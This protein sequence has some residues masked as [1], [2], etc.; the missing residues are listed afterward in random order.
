MKRLSFEGK[1]DDICGTYK[2]VGSAGRPGA[3]SYGMKKGVFGLIC[4]L[5]GLLIVPLCGFLYLRFGIPPVAV[6][7]PAF[8]FEKQIV[9]VPLDAR[10]KREMPGASPLQPTAENVAAGAAIY[11]QNCAFCHGLPGHDSVYADHM[12]PPTPQLWKAHGHGV[13]G[14][15]DDPVGETFWKVKNGIRLTGMP[16]YADLLSQDQM[17]QVSLLLSTA[18]KPQP[19]PV[20]SQ[21]QQ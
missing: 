7:D 13:V 5:L 14:V 21:L 12:Y 20:Q 10:I 2:E 16:A 8:P 6:T 11:R 15:S 17:W 19:A 3:S 9:H 18:D 4:F 1:S